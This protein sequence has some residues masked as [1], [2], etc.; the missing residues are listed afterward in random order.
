MRKR[1]EVINVGSGFAMIIGKA[2]IEA[3]EH[4]TNSGPKRNQGPG[5]L[6]KSCTPTLSFILLTKDLSPAFAAPFPC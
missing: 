1:K 5:A 6:D 3:V 4:L 2:P